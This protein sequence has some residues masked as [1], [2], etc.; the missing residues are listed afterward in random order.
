MGD[1][2]FVAFHDGDGVSPL[3]YGHWGGSGVF[4]VLAKTREQMKPRPDDVPYIAA[5]FC[6]ALCEAAGPGD[7]GVGL[8]NAKTLAELRADPDAFSDGDAGLI[9]VKV[10]EWKAEPL[11]GY[12]HG[13]DVRPEEAKKLA[14]F[15]EAT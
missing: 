3:V 7:S 6:A 5:R 13:D 1:R 14:E 15:N 8:S 11:C 9:L 10:P 2:V 12:Y 4:Q